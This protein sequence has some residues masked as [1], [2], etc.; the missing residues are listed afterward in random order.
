MTSLAAASPDPRIVRPK[1]RGRERN[2][3]LQRRRLGAHRGLRA[4]LHGRRAAGDRAMGRTGD[5]RGLLRRLLVRRR[6]VPV[7]RHPHGHRAP[8]ARLQGVVRQDDHGRQ[9]P[10]VRLHRPG[11]L[12]EPPPPAPH[13]R[14]PRGRP[15]QAG[16]RRFLAHALAVPVS[17][18]DQGQ[19]RQ[20]PRPEDL[21]VPPR[22]ELA[23]RHR[24]HRL[25]RLAAVGAGARPALRACHVDHVPRLH[26]VDQHGAE[27]LDARPPLRLPP[28]RRRAR[29]RE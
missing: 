22:R 25:Q 17:V 16:V 18:R 20:R 23:V 10:A 13:V 26:A 29:Q 8:G 5:R 1:S 19:R 14:R 6:R 4:G 27:L 21:A 3:D 7:L 2:A 15:E 12:G 24:S 11:H 28:P 9:Q